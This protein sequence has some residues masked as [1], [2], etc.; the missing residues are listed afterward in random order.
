MTL[1]EPLTTQS[2][3][4]RRVRWWYAVAVVGLIAVCS[5]SLAR[6]V[7]RAREAARRSDCKCQFCSLKLAMHNYHE[8]HG[9]FPPAYVEGPDGTPWHSWR[10]L[11]LPF[12]DQRAIY[13]A[14]RFDEPWNGPSNRALAATV[15]P[16]WL[17][18]PSSPGRG[19]TP[20]S[21]Y[22]VV[23]GAGTV[24][25]GPNVTSLNEI[26]ND[27]EVTL[28]AEVEGLD[29][30]W[31]EPRDLAL[32]TMSFEINPTHGPG[33]SSSHPGGAHVQAIQD[34]ARFM[35]DDSPAAELRRRLTIIPPDLAEAP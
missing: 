16:T 10:T 3:Q 6:A 12:V 28:I 24:F 14:Y 33:I 17:Q 22:V 7:G 15:Q 31:M 5:V 13:D 8:V 32:D 11:L 23:A 26:A 29:I 19:V 21:N 1:V 18:C 27:E 9:S 2:P 35:T 34:G 20:F 25:P 30:H 4:P